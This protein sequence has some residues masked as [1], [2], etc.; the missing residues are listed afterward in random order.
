MPTGKAERSR[1]SG[2]P[3]FEQP[4]GAGP[5][6]V[7]RA[8]AMRDVDQR[9]RDRRQRRLQRLFKRRRRI[10]RRGAAIRPGSIQSA[11]RAPFVSARSG[12]SGS[13]TPN[14]SPAAPASSRGPVRTRRVAGGDGATL[15]AWLRG[16]ASSSRAE[17]R[18]SSGIEALAFLVVED[19]LDD[20]RR[21]RAVQRRHMER[22]A[23]AA[24]A[25]G[26]ERHGES[27]P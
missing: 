4:R 19:R 26:D 13:D 21:N 3:A 22:R 8:L 11:A 27:A 20:A 12:V 1:S 7:D 18:E 5:A 2:T 25:G 24:A 9:V 23:H 14:A 15:A 10:A 6:D 17:R 16:M